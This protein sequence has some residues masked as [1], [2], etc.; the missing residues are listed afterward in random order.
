M[1]D[2][3]MVPLLISVLQCPFPHDESPHGYCPSTLCTM[4]TPLSAPQRN[5]DFSFP[6]FLGCEGE[7]RTPQRLQK[8]PERYAYGR[9]QGN[10]FEFPLV[11]A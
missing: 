3:M 10:S 4:H 9:P 7:I 5:G 2:H 11:T 8:S 1:A 6:K